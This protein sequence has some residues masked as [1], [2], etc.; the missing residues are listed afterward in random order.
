M[1]KKN[2]TLLLGILI[3]SL[4]KIHASDSVYIAVKG[5]FSDVGVKL[6]WSASDASSWRRTNECGFM[7]ERYVVKEN[8]QLVDTPVKQV[9]NS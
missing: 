1:Y 8:G 6:R 3:F 9:I 2:F 7:V 4:L 5:N